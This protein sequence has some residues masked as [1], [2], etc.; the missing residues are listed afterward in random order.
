MG[1]SPTVVRRK[2]QRRAKA[3]LFPSNDWTVGQMTVGIDTT[4]RLKPTIWRRQSD[5]RLGSP[6]VRSGCT[7]PD[8][9]SLRRPKSSFGSSS[10]QERST[11]YPRRR[12]LGSCPLGLSPA[13]GAQFRR[14]RSR[15]LRCAPQDADR[16][17]TLRSLRR[18]EGTAAG[19]TAKL[20]E[21]RGSKKLPRPH[22]KQRRNRGVRRG[23]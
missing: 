2:R 6:F 23:R 5:A 14:L 3:D 12:D 17:G 11:E 1:L 9:P 15:W 21:D 16:Y 22:A 10:S 7:R 13:F 19:A 4:F 8:R 20:R 18:V